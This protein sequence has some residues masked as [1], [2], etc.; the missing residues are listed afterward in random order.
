M[1]STEIAED[2]RDADLADRVKRFGQI[3]RGLAA[4]EARVRGEH[5]DPH[6]TFCAQSGVR[7]PVLTPRNSLATPSCQALIRSI[8]LIREIRVPW[9]R[10]A[11]ALAHPVVSRLR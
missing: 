6:T 4:P 9:K 10:G 8:Q 7:I 2:S 1:P 5:R 11:N 3:L